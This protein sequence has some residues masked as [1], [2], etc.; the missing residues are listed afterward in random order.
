MVDGTIDNK[1]LGVSISTITLSM[2]IEGLCPKT[3]EPLVGSTLEVK[4]TPLKKFLRM[5]IIYN[6][7]EELKKEPLDLETFIQIIGSELEAQLGVAVYVCG[8][9]VLTG[10]VDLTVE[11][12]SKTHLL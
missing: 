12:G 2:P 6:W 7:I 10:D 11:Y 8:H 1:Y 5:R 4:Y 3:K 9:F